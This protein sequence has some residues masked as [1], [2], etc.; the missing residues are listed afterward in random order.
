MLW[1][2]FDLDKVF[3]AIPDDSFKR[4]SRNWESP[5]RTT[6]TSITLLWKRSCQFSTNKTLTS[7]SFV[8]CWR[9]NLSYIFWTQVTL[10]MPPLLQPV[11]C[12]NLNIWKFRRTMLK[13]CHREGLRR[14]Y[15]QVMIS[16]WLHIMCICQELP[17]AFCVN[18]W[19]FSFSGWNS[20]CANKVCLPPPFML[21][22]GR[23]LANQSAQ[24]T[25]DEPVSHIQRY[26]SKISNSIIKTRAQ[27]RL[28]R[29]W[30]FVDAHW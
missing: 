27:K 16:T 28:E 12:K 21:L 2:A 13:T 10:E 17:N 26:V 25:M 15:S 29:L 6:L 14:W 30:I 3:D 18:T 1:D 8:I 5:Q 22:P 11:D 23:L 19:N 9:S 7:T 24:S 20:L 4:K